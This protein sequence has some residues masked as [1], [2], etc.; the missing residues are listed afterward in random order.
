VF[1]KMTGLTETEGLKTWL[2]LVAV[3]GFTSAVI[4]LILAVLF[5][6]V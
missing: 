5:S 6:A 1:V 3:L 4:S 2:P